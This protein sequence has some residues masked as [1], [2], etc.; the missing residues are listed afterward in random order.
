MP[1]PNEILA[2][3]RDL[4]NG[5]SA[6]ALAWH[7]YF[8]ALVG[9]LVLGLRPSKRTVGLLLAIPL[10]SVGGLA[11]WSGNP[12]NAIL[13]ILAGLVLAFIALAFSSESVKVASGSAF[14]VGVL[15][16]GF[17]WVYPHFLMASSVWQYLYLSPLGVIPCPTISALVGLTLILGGLG[18]RSWSLVLSMF[19][20]FYGLVGAAG[21]GVQIDWALFAGALTLAVSSMNRDRSIAEKSH[22]KLVK[23]A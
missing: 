8:G 3:L 7:I 22:A 21:L 13:F 23:D 20:I 2:G 6:L 5:W 14:F 17:G 15:L 4:A 10:L 1:T 12:F 11:G 16:V 9:G 18:S 19:G